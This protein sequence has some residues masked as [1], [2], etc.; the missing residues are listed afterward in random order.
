MTSAKWLWPASRANDANHFAL[1]SPAD[2][3]R[4]FLPPLWLG[5]Q[6]VK[7]DVSQVSHKLRK[8]DALE[9]ARLIKLAYELYKSWDA[10]GRLGESDY[11]PSLEAFGFSAP[12]KLIWCGIENTR[13]RPGPRTRRTVDTEWTPMAITGVKRDTVYVVIRGTVHMRDWVANAEVIPAPFKVG[14]AE[15]GW[16]H[17][18]FK[19]AFSSMRQAIADSVILLAASSGAQRLLVTGHSLGGAIATLAY[20]DLGFSSKLPTTMDRQCCV[21]GSPLVGNQAFR[22]RL[23]SNGLSVVR[24]ENIGDPVPKLPPLSSLLALIPVGDVID[25]LFDTGDAFENH[26]ID[27]YLSGLQDY[28]DP[29]LV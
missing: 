6:I 16:V 3:G 14:D 7:W 20:A 5:A 4:A 17:D 8:D 29:G 25:L 23:L 27:S 18:G 11:A 24:F 1:Q 15:L 13:R 21:F 10:A 19:D 12:G 26:G 28:A 22:E 2:H 9:C